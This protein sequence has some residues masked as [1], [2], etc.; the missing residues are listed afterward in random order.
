MISL[1][2]SQAKVIVV[3]NIVVLIAVLLSIFGINKERNKQEGK[4]KAIS[5]AVIVFVMFIVIMLLQVYTMN[6]MIYGECHS[7]AWA[8]SSVAVVGTLIYLG[9]F[10]YLIF[11]KHTTK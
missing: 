10:I 4:I 6:C 8:I 11:K 2:S 7:L 1:W 3:C 9:I 5:K